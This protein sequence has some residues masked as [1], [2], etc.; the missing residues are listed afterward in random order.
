MS[1]RI[2]SSW[3]RVIRAPHR[4]IQ[5]QDRHTPFPDV[6]PRDS[7]LPY[8][9]GRSYGDS[10][11]NTGGALLHTRYLDK[12]IA[13]DSE[14]GV[15]TC[16][17]GVKFDDIL[18]IALPHGWFPPVT[19]GTRFV[20]IGGA[21]ANDVHGKNHHAAGTFSRHVRRLELL[22][23][24]GDRLLCAPDQNAEW[25]AA[26]VAGLGLTGLITWAEIQL[27]RVPGPWMRV[28][29]IRYSNLAE[30]MAL[31]AESDRHFEYT[32]A[33]VDCLA[34]GKQLG[35]GLLQRARHA[36][37]SDKL[38]RTP[39]SRG[40]PFVPPFSLINNTSTWLFN[41]AIY[42]RPFR[43]RIPTDEHYETFFYPLD[44]IRNWNRIYGPRGMYQYQCVIP[45]QAA[46]EA[47]TALLTA[48][49][50]SGLGSFLAVLKQFGDL[51]SAGLLSF[52]RP[53]IT[54]ALDFPNRGARLE[55]LLHS[56]D[57]VVADAGG[58]IYPAKDGRM[59]GSLFRSGFPQWQQFA[60]FIDPACSS[61]FWRRVMGDN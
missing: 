11:L 21:I 34:R 33:W 3:G 36:E 5:P 1:S 59:P 41:Q 16:E 38:P 52:P 30:F 42:H 2:V 29:T 46:H 4:V 37:V 14:T 60:R 7:I 9:N 43:T 26:T 13:F 10:C 19:P 53:G 57:A 35:R 54:L 45:H 55:R 39:R 44:G 51:P 31:S 8:G 17:A 6:G 12:F 61:N 22:R 49:T 23:S 18:Q 56:L 58:R 47:T 28:E 40:V 20:T 15:M 50:R 32:V 24:N 27:R 48:I 25:F